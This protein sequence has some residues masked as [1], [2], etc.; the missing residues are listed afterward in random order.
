MAERFSTLSQ[1]LKTI[2]EYATCKS[3]MRF[4]TNL[5]LVKT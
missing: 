3:F 4:G 1:V 2:V 5:N